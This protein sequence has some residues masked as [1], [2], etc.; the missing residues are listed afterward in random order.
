MAFKVT[1][2]VLLILGLASLGVG[3]YMMNEPD[4]EVP[5]V[6]D[7]DDIP[8]VRDWEVFV[9][10]VNGLHF[11]MEYPP[12]TEVH[13]VSF[14]IFEIKYVG[15]QSE[16]NTEITDGYYASLQFNEATSAQSYAEA[17]NQA[18]QVG[19]VRFAGRG[20]LTYQSDNELSGELVT[21]HVFSIEGQSQLVDVSYQT[22]GDTSEEYEKEVIAILRTLVF[23]GPLFTLTCTDDR[24]LTFFYGENEQ[25]AA[26]SFQEQHY[27]LSRTPASAVAEYINGD[28]GIEFVEEGGDVQL[29]LPSS[30]SA[31]TCTDQIPTSSYTNASSSLIRITAPEAGSVATSPIQLQGEARGQWFF[32]ATA[33]VVVVNWD[34]LIIGESFVTAEGEWMTEEFVPFS[35]TIDYDLASTTYNASGTVIFQRSNPSDLPENDAAVEI[36]VMLE[37]TDE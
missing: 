13:E 37:V 17:Q 35:G 10:E 24:Q 9:G 23:G 21:H 18:G 26:L 5:D 29:T 7:D 30:F 14:G 33:P 12:E 16:P 4:G 27:L 19:S 15:P 3:F 6:S 22:F 34:G 2:A 32:E 1:V 25:V 20:A 8:E 36:P 28:K 11:A 31:V